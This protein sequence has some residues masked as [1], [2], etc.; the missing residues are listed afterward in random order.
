MRTTLRR[1]LISAFCLLA[2]AALSPRPALAQ[3]VGSISQ[4]TTSQTFVGNAQATATHSDIEVV[5]QTGHSIQVS[6]GCIVTLDGSQNG[7]VW[8]V[9]AAN[10]SASGQIAFAD[11]Y[12]PFL[13]LTFNFGSQAACSGSAYTVQYTGFQFPLPDLSS[14]EPQFNAVSVS[15]P[16]AIITSGGNNIFWE[17]P[18]ITCYNP[19]ASVAYLQVMNGPSA[20]TLGSGVVYQAGIAPNSSFQYVGTKLV[21]NLGLSVGASTAPLG[22]TAV[23]TPISCSLESGSQVSFISNKF[24]SQ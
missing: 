7:S 10:T 9:L 11:G 16:V 18:A 4:L 3:Y 19:S 8:W 17:M 15:S 5:A 12:F 21:G 2:L 20:G 24:A 22:N 13:R 23:A 1:I 6:G 14:P